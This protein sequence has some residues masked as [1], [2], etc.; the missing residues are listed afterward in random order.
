[1]IDSRWKQWI[2]Y[3]PEVFECPQKLNP[4]CRGSPLVLQLDLQLLKKNKTKNNNNHL[5][6]P[7]IELYNSM[8][9]TT[10]RHTHH[11]VGQWQVPGCWTYFLLMIGCQQPKSLDLRG[12]E[13]LEVTTY[14]H[15][16]IIYIY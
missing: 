3:C 16:C 1:M 4:A 15:T 8:P 2:S 7:F 13:S 9:A 14:T 11:Q 12:S 6:V 10:G 5:S